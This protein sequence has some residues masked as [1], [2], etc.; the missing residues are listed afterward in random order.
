[1]ATQLLA[2][3]EQLLK[4]GVLGVEEKHKYED[5]ILKLKKAYYEEFSRPEDEISDNRLAELDLE[6]RLVSEAFL[7]TLGAKAPKN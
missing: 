2:V 4:L 6:L 5:N 1:M 7:A 3:L